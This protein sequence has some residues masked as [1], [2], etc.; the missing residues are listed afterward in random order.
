MKK[1]CSSK[2]SFFNLYLI[3]DP[4]KD[5]LRCRSSDYTDD[6][7]QHPKLEITYYHP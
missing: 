7:T 6:P 5:N 1:F 2:T 4:S 3:C